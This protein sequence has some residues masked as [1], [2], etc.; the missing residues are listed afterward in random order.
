[1]PGAR[2]LQRREPTRPS[3]MAEALQ[4]SHGGT[5]PRAP[6]NASVRRQAPRGPTPRWTAGRSTHHS[7]RGVPGSRA[8]I[9]R[10]RGPRKD[11]LNVRPPR[12][13]WKGRDKP[14][15]ETSAYRLRV[16]PLG[17]GDA[18]ALGT[19][20]HRYG[21]KVLNGPRVVVRQAAQEGHWPTHPPDA[22]RQPLRTRR[23]ARHSPIGSHMAGRPP[24]GHPR[25]ERAPF[26]LPDGRRNPNAR[27]GQRRLAST[28]LGKA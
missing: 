28:A 20:G 3:A 5:Q 2:Q 17:H 19:P 25:R 22:G 12:T 26:A 16:H 21:P 11:L 9:P 4:T 27:N 7:P 8:R 24:G 13:E 14:G 6:R 18:P 10:S 1:M 23:H 15:V